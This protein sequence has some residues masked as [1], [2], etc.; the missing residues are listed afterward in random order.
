MV[1]LSLIFFRKLPAV[2]AWTG[3]AMLL[4]IN[5]RADGYFM[6]SRPDMEALLFALVALILMYRGFEKERYALFALGVLT[7][8]VAYLFKQTA[9]MFA[10]VPLIKLILKRDGVTASELVMI[11]APPA[12][13]VITIVAIRIAAPTVDF[14]M[15]EALT[16]WKIQP[17]RFG[18]AVISFLALM[19]IIPAALLLGVATTRN[20]DA[21]A[22]S[23]AGAREQMLWLIAACIIATPASMLSFAKVGGVVNS[24]IPALLPLITLSTVLIARA[25]CA[26]ASHPA[27]SIWTAYGFSALL[28]MIML[29]SAFGGSSDQLRAIITG[30]THGDEHYPRVIEYVSKLHGRVVCPDD[31]TIPIR[32]LKQTGRSFWGEYVASHSTL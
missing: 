14:Y 25:W 9:A 18:Y 23:D 32:A 26:I 30:P 11:L 31:P 8:C 21:A 6:Q 10:M 22:S 24:Y 19:P 15:I 20:D 12:A 1:M 13:I 4:A 2:F 5:L 29:A 28:A 17:A 16:K 7:L 27:P 3:V